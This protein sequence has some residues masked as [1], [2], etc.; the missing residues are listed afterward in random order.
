MEFS[1][2]EY[3]GGL[4]L[5]T[6]G[7]LPDLGIKPASLEPSALVGRFFIPLKLPCE[8]PHPLSVSGRESAFEHLKSVCHPLPCYTPVACLQKKSKFLFLQLDLSRIGFFFFFKF[9]FYIGVQLIN[10]M[11]V[12]GAFQ[13]DSVIH[14]YVTIIL[15]KFFSQL[16]C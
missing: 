16:S 15:F 7:I 10:N 8:R 4:P 11:L 9:L 12:S 3:W 2:Q 6:S 5:A 1:R 14:I 13:S